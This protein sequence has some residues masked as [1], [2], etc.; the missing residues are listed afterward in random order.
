MLTWQATLLTRRR[1]HRAGEL[2]SWFVRRAA[3]TIACAWAGK[4]SSCG[5]HRQA[6]EPREVPPC[7]SE[8]LTNVVCRQRRRN[9]PQCAGSSNRSSLSACAPCT[10]LSWSGGVCSPPSRRSCSG[11]WRG[12]SYW[13][14]QLSPLPFLPSSRPAHMKDTH[15][16]NNTQ[17]GQFHA[18]STQDLAVYS[19]FSV[20]TNI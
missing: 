12:T 18:R 5:R 6:A 3:T 14:S 9:L 11:S 15:R 17:P 2:E 1:H 13:S 19:L 4:S 10:R 8:R 7:A 16:I 20:N